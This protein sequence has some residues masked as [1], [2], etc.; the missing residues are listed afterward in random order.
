MA[1]WQAGTR[2]LTVKQLPRSGTLAH[3]DAESRKTPS[4]SS[5]SGFSIA[6]SRGWF[7]TL[8]PLWGVEEGVTM[9]SWEWACSTLS[10]LP[11]SG[12]EGRELLR[13]Q[14]E[15]KEGEG[16]FKDKC[17]RCGGACPSSQ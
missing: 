7:Y 3:P 9:A 1:P 6:L 8:A 13:R 10:C 11:E 2:L 16:A 14:K 5:A 17:G 4:E 15:G 12:E